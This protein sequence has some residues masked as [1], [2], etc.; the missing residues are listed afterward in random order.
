MSKAGTPAGSGSQPTYEELKPQ[1]QALSARRVG[2][3]QPTYEELKL[4]IPLIFLL[5]GISSQP[6]YE[7]LKHH[8]A[9]LSKKITSGFPA[10]L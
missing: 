7:E 9:E 6:T 1:K 4:M 8:T 3:S 10:Y 2:C 5:P